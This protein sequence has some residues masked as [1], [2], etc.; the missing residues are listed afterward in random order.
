MKLLYLLAIPLLLIYSCTNDPSNGTPIDN[1]SAKVQLFDDLG[2]EI[3]PAN[4]VSMTIDNVKPKRTGTSNNSGNI[5]ILSVA[6]GKYDVF[7][8]KS[9]YDTYWVYQHEHGQRQSGIDGVKLS[10]FS[11]TRLSNLTVKFNTA[12]EKY[13]IEG[14]ISP[15]T[16]DDRWVRLFFGASDVSSTNYSYSPPV[17]LIVTNGS[18]KVDLNK[19]DIAGLGIAQGAKFYVIG[20]GASAVSATYLHPQTKKNVYTSLSTNPSNIAEGIVE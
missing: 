14:D 7:F 5:Q 12:G 17:P 3:K 2:N 8:S 1:L 15:V 10:M 4:G 19:N 9:G 13:E 6:P 20:Y 16:A 18:F 11:T